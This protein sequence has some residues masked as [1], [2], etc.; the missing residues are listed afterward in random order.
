MRGINIRVTEKKKTIIE[1]IFNVYVN[2]FFVWIALVL[3]LS[4]SM[5]S[6]LI[7][8][9]YPYYGAPGTSFTYTTESVAITAIG[10]FIGLAFLVVLNI[11][12]VLDRVPAEKTIRYLAVYLLFASVFWF[13]IANTWPD[14][15]SRDLFGAAAQLG[16]RN[17]TLW[18]HGWYM[19]RY[20]FQIPYTLFL[21]IC[22][23]VFGS[24]A[25]VA[26]EVINSICIAATG[27]LLSK[28]TLLAFGNAAGN[29][30]VIVNAL[31]LPAIFY[32]TFAYGNPVSMPFA[33]AA[34]LIQL[35]YFRKPQ[36][37]KIACIAV[38][39]TISILLKSTMIV[40]LFAM[41]IVWVVVSVKKRR[42]RDVV[43]C[44]SVFVIYVLC[45]HGIN[46]AVAQKYNV[47]TD[48]GL[49]KIA[50]IAM[51]LRANQYPVVPDMPGYYD[52]FV[53]KWYGDSY[54]P[55]RAIDDSKQSLQYTW[56][57]FSSDPK[58]ALEFMAK[59][60]SIE[61]ADPSY[62]SLLSSNFAAEG[63]QKPGIMSER[64]MTP[65]LRSIYYGKLNRFAWIE[66]DALQFLTFAGA[67]VLLY[68]RRCELTIEI[69][70]PL[71]TCLGIA[72]IYIFWEAKSQYIMP[73]AQFS[74]IYSSSGLYLLSLS[75]SQKIK[76]K[77]TKLNPIFN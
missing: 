1:K 65:I 20:P 57:V 19:E 32:S 35:L 39:L 60:L 23:Y 71:I 9:R 76:N 75:I 77:I 31:F 34:M 33:V 49:S 24:N 6:L 58:Y 17:S 56:D 27:Y 61:W 30:A 2:Y 22:L 11:T 36:K 14:W 72:F 16:H 26:I 10:A 51:G 69:M 21:K 45:S 5:L 4:V 42:I 47:I 70:T 15:D 25:Y 44:V 40:A 48:N 62:E 67:A 66:M 18:A 37:R 12:G 68:R 53:W 55:N 52:A 54:D 73:I 3:F 43:A 13:V 29:I 41:V 7:T 64:P 8:V 50:W 46:Y 59:K 28:Y 74:I 38:L 63:P